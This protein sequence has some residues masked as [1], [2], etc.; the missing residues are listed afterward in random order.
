M[1]NSLF[2][3]IIAASIIIVLIFAYTSKNKLASYVAYIILASMAI[4]MAFNGLSGII[5]DID[6]LSFLESFFRFLNDIIVFIEIG[7]ILFLLFFTKHKSNIILL[8]VAIITYVI[9]TLVI[10]LNIFG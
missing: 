3:L 10:E 9:L 4:S 7:L 8:K 2:L 5:A 6:F 1:I